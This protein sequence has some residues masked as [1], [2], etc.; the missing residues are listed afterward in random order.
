[1]PFI[2]ANPLIVAK[3]VNFDIAFVVHI[4]LNG[5]WKSY[6]FHLFWQKLEQEKY[7]LQLKLEQ[8]AFSERTYGEEVESLKDTLRRERDEYEQR[9]ETVNQTELST[10]KGQVWHTV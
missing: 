9:L 1:M 10:L 3:K 7:S 5:Q 8:K 4:H 2:I 6:D